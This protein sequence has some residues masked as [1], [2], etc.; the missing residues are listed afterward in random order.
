[1]GVR[2][3]NIAGV[4]GVSVSSLAVASAILTQAAPSSA[5]PRQPVPLREA[6]NDAFYEN[7]GTFFVN[8]S[9]YNQINSILGQGS[10]IHSGFPEKQI[11][12]DVRA[13]HRL[14]EDA[15]NQ[16]VGSDPV[17]RTP[18][19]PNPYDSSVM[20]MPPANFNNRP[21]GSELNFETIPLR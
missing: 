5:E 15:L 14:Y 8:R 11:E 13:V 21:L 9:I 16:Q 1:M 6:F 20:M 19:L 17:I 7:S 4:L 12:R 2:F 3:K 18:D 10:I